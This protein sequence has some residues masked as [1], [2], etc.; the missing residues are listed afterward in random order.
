MSDEA[1]RIA[2]ALLAANVPYSGMSW[3]GF[4]LFGDDKSIKELRRLQ[5]AAGTAETFREEVIRLRA[6]T[7][8]KSEP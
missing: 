4:N 6:L 2:D 3:G 8:G 1:L 7:N 5:H